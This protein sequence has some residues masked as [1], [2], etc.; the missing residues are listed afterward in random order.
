LADYAIPIPGLVVR[1][2]YLW[3]HEAQAG[4]IEGQKHRPCAIVVCVERE[5]GELIV[6]VAP[7][8]RRRPKNPDTAI[9]LTPATRRRL[10][11]GNQ[12]N[13][14]MPTEVNSFY[15]PGPDLR[16]TPKGKLAYGELPAVVF[17]A[18]VKKILAA[19]ATQNTV[20]RDP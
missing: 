5:A 14:I 7:V 9:E 17:E 18:L 13:W 8:T 2:A 15:W 16:P 19:G 3:R 12:P 11:L 20:S 10:G 1:Y 4:Q 6:T